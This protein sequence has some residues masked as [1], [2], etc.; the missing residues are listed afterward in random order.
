MMWNSTG[1]QNAW[2]KQ[3]ILQTPVCLG[4]VNNSSAV[5]G[6]IKRCWRLPWYSWSVQLLPCFWVGSAFKD[7]ALQWEMQVSVPLKIRILFSMFLSIL[8]LDTEV[9]NC[10]FYIHIQTPWHMC[11]CTVKG[12]C[13]D[14]KHESVYLKNTKFCFL[15]VV[16][17]AFSVLY[18]ICFH[19]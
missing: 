16:W 7:T 9:T 17:V 4:F 15:I 14:G 6:Y 2:V 8:D 5:N 12:I 11:A 3:V 13:F 10:Y 19:L 1:K 18:P